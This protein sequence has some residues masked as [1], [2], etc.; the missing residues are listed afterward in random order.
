MNKQLYDKDDS[1]RCLSLSSLFGI[2]WYCEKWDT[3]H[4]VLLS[5]LSEQR[6]FR[7]CR[8][9]LQPRGFSAA[10]SAQIG[11]RKSFLRVED[12]HPLE[13]GEIVGV[14]SPRVAA[15]RFQLR[16]QGLPGDPG[17]PGAGGGSGW[18]GW[19][20]QR[21][22][23]PFDSGA[24]DVVGDTLSLRRVGRGDLVDAIIAIHVSQ[25]RKLTLVETK[26]A[27]P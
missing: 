23:P 10:P 7:C 11:R 13:A 27:L 17:D 25:R 14:H 3:P 20:P 12:G 8:H 18:P 15:E 9:V 4:L 21:P 26:T 2:V 6:L 24:G 22:G 19:P 1:S 16:P 5:C